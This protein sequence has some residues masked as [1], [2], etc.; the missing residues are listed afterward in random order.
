MLPA[1]PASEPCFPSAES[2]TLRI[3]LLT[4]SVPPEPC[5]VGDFTARLAAELGAQGVAAE[6]VSGTA[7][8]VTAVPGLR[9]R[10]RSLAL[11]LLHIQYPTNGFGSGLAPHLLSL[12]GA[13][14]PV[15]VTLHEHSQARWRRRLSSL[16]FALR[17]RALIFTTDGERAGFVRTVP[18]IAPRSVIIPISS[19]IPA[20]A[21]EP[22]PEPTVVYF[23]QI[24]PNKGLDDFLAAAR[25]AEQA[26]LGW[27]FVII[28]AVLPRFRAHAEALRAAA[29]DLAVEWILGGTAEAVGERL[30]RA[31]AAYLPFPDGASLRRGSMLAALANGLPVL[32]TRG[33]QTPADLAQTVRFVTDPPDLVAALA[34]PLADEAERARMAAASLA[35]AQ[36]FAWPRIARRHAGLYRAVVTGSSL[37]EV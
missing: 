16:T 28:G 18:W 17:S 10:L 2:R 8:G 24:R 7:W 26:R 36:A 23:G 20:G 13:P 14:M 5:G 11:D 33:G 22:G 1:P 12:V 27:R 32:T 31:H 37:A 35:Y 15:V 29:A 19:N 21:P 9:S 30:R 25:L 3:G 4:G 34:G 6:L